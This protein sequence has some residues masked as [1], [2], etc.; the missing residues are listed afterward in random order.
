M[1]DGKNEYN[2]DEAT[3]V[4]VTMQKRIKCF[5]FFSDFD[6]RMSRSMDENQHFK[7]EFTM[8]FE[9][10]P[11]LH[12]ELSGKFLIEDGSTMSVD[13]PGSGSLNE[14]VY[15]AIHDP[16]MY[17][18]IMEMGMHRV[19]PSRSTIMTFHKKIEYLKPHPYTTDCF[20]YQ[21]LMKT[22]PSVSVAMF[23][24][25]SDW[26]D[27]S[28]PVY[29]SR[30]ECLLHCYWRWANNP[31][32]VNL[33]ITFT[34]E[35]FLEAEQTLMD[36]WIAQ[37]NGQASNA[38]TNA[39]QA[40]EH[41]LKMCVEDEKYYQVYTTYKKV[42]SAYCKRDCLEESYY[43][44]N[45]YDAQYF[46]N[47]DSIIE[48]QWDTGYTIYTSHQAKLDGPVFLGNIGGHAHIW[49]GISLISIVRYVL[50]VLHFRMDMICSELSRCYCCCC[51]TFW[52]N[53][54]KNQKSQN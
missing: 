47:N 51:F 41:F 4:L 2:C 28:L 7:D 29:R 1:T 53:S 12:L 52:W 43:V 25:N 30:G 27:T 17:P 3:P 16:T 54:H 32:C 40:D 11:Y 5:T 36:D 18:D 14:K 44:D 10:F 31:Q 49:L 50:T 48:I 38:T 37:H 21:R 13:G 42:C 26:T 15:L 45:T 19:G 24:N 20:A 34:K 39:E 35:M 22:S 23:S 46:V 9:K 8:N 6:G 33:Y